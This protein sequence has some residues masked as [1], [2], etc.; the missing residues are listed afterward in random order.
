MMHH[1]EWTLMGCLLLTKNVTV[2]GHA[3]DNTTYPVV[4]MGWLPRIIKLAPGVWLTF[5]RITMMG[6]RPIIGP[7]FAF[8]CYSPGGVLYQRDVISHQPRGV[9]NALRVPGM[10]NT[11]R[12]R[13]GVQEVYGWDRSFCYTTVLTSQCYAEST[14]VVD[15]AITVPAITQGLGG[16]GGYVLWFV[17]S[18]LV[19][20]AVLDPAC[21]IAYGIE[22]CYA[23]AVAA[24]IEID[25]PSSPP[26]PLSGASP[27][28]PAS[29]DLIAHVA[30]PVVVSCVALLAFAGWWY[31]RRR[32]AL[33][34][35][36]R[37][38]EP[39]PG[40]DT[41][42]VLT[43]IQ[44]ST[45]MWETLPGAIMDKCLATH[46]AIMRRCLS[47]HHGSE[48]ATEGDAFIMAFHTAKDA[49]A[50]CL[51]V[52][53]QLMAA[54]WLTELLAHA[55]ACEVYATPTTL[56][57]LDYGADEAVMKS[58]VSDNSHGGDRITPARVRG[59]NL[60]RNSSL[61]HSNSMLSESLS[62][63]PQNH[64]PPTTL[65]TTTLIEGVAAPAVPP[66]SSHLPGGYSTSYQSSAVNLNALHLMF[67][68]RLDT[69]EDCGE[70]QGDAT[71][72]NRTWLEH[73]RNGW[74]LR[75][76][77]ITDA[78]TEAFVYSG[79]TIGTSDEKLA[80]LLRAMGRAGKEANEMLL[81]RGLRVRMGVHSGVD[82][83]D[84]FHNKAS[85]RTQFGGPSLSRAREV[86]N[87]APGGA[88]L[89][90][91]AAF[92]AVTTRGGRVPGAVMAHIGDF[93][94]EA[95]AQSPGEALPLYAAMQPQL[96]AR[97]VAGA[98][99]KV[100][101]KVSGGVFD[102]PVGSVTVNFMA[103]PCHKTLRAWRP[104]LADLAASTFSSLVTACVHKHNGYVVEHGEGFCLSAF[105]KAVDAVHYCIDMKA[106]MMT[107]PWPAELLEHELCEEVTEGSRVVTRGPRVKSGSDSCS[108]VFT[109]INPSSGRMEYRGKVMNRAARIAS[110]ATSG[111]SLISGDCWA[112]CQRAPAGKAVCA[113]PRGTMDL[114]GVGELGVFQLCAPPPE[115]L[116]TIEDHPHEALNAIEDHPHDDEYITGNGEIRATAPARLDTGEEHT[117]V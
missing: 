36:Q 27:T 54:E 1:D 34:P 60:M 24:Q 99:L 28:P 59:L 9:T 72:I 13:P 69:V 105:C 48:S 84:I 85:S 6:F 75:S 92:V 116:D 90:S 103:M 74:L 55:S 11:P 64:A 117:I 79:A 52:Q 44:D 95:D 26:P 17:N 20:P 80:D 4:H 77:T 68:S 18:T 31:W 43:D 65:R 19:A 93:R 66:S 56:L 110:K 41:T 50:F 73:L 114:K 12:S 38:S 87:A 108:H 70:D 7:D 71:P 107:A 30:V 83:A 5:E 61:G 33:P 47:E 113:Y 111:V 102:A 81:F 100:A 51:V 104:E 98:P 101:E 106:L 115:A 45:N 37:F 2:V 8:M 3:P 86:C 14:Q 76:G 112:E 88:V 15:V 39:Q 16:S 22:R 29:E 89:L 96:L 91:K 78:A 40:P 58:I 62:T 63:T 57:Q 67:G 49:V 53:E 46:N 35:H 21:L 109:A 97:Y 25:F 23:D 82:A 10:L 32:Q 94:T 42:L